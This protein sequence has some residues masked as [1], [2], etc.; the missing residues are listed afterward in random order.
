[1][2]EVLHAAT[3]R[4]PDP[5]ARPVG[6]YERLAY[7][8]QTRDLALAAQPGGHPKGF[9]YDEAIAERAVMFA[10]KFCKHHKGEWAGK[11]LML[12]DWQR[13]VLRCVFGWL[14]PD[15]TRRFHTAYEEVPRKNGKTQKCG[16]V[17][18]YLMVADGEPGAEIYATATK[19]EQAKLVWEGAKQMV[20]QSPD[21]KKWVRAYQKSLVCARTNSFFKPLGADSDTLDGLNPHGHICD[22][23]HAHKKRALF[24]VMLTGMGARRQPL[25]F[26]ITTAGVYDPASIGWEMHTHAQQV[27]DGSIEDDGFF[28]IIFAADEGDDPFDPDTWAK[29]NPN[30][31]VSVKLEYLA[32]QAK[33]A[34][35]QPSFLNTFLRLHLN[36]WTQQVTRWIPIEKWNERSEPLAPITSYAGRDAFLGLDL[37]TSLDICALAIDIPSGEWHDVFWNF[38]VPEELVRQRTLNAK[39]PDYAAWVR[40]GWLT[41]V[42][43]NVVD[44][45][46]IRRD[47]NAL[48]D[49]LCVRQLA[50][51]P[52]NATQLT[53][54]LQGDGWSVDPDAKK[55][56]LVK[57][58]QGP[59][60]MSEP[61]KKFEELV[62]SS[63]FRHGGNPVARW[64][65]DNAVI[66]YDVNNNIA[67][68]KRSALGKIDGV[69]AAIMALSRAIVTQPLKRSV[70]ESRGVRL[71]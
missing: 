16:A 40:E 38:Y 52:W 65:V 24:D 33:L 19:E 60:S 30:L 61:S 26:I 37:S 23:L 68:D 56:Q 41:A 64:M 66:R 6:K 51:D 25:T 21:L 27:L 57:V 63:R 14:K 49:I 10:E 17:G 59:Q 7:A 44:Y 31:G 43:G 47:I 18:N 3:S 32:K 36:V 71:F 22:E 15:G 62:V 20:A 34:K 55:E 70:Y 58:R 11:P 45:A 39:M 8:R 28:A 48:R 67:P 54:E 69:V 1:M 53:T 9:V 46:W 4:E 42:P 5:P 2:V 12:E 35:D 13:F 50:F 29:A